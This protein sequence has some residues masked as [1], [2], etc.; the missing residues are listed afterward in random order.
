MYDRVYRL[1]QDYPHLQFS[2]NGG[3]QTLEDVNLHLSHGVI[4]VMIGREAIGR[5]WIF[6]QADKRIFGEAYN[7]GLSRREIITRYAEYAEE[8]FQ[9]YA[10]HYTSVGQRVIAH[11]DSDSDSD[12]VDHSPIGIKSS[13]QY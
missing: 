7:V 13:E 9:Q 4:G 6:S 11:S 2:L 1:V 8:Q 3:V 12:S 10:I 5:P